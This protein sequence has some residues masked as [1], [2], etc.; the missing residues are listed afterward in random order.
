[1]DDAEQDDTRWLESI[2]VEEKQPILD[3]T[4]RI[5]TEGILVVKDTI[6]TNNLVYRKARFNKRLGQV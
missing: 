6:V 2:E 5:G 4:E 3:G 1:M